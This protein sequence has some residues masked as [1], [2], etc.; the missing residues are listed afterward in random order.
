M[1]P[2][3]MTQKDVSGP[4]K[5]KAENLITLGVLYKFKKVNAEEYLRRVLE[6]VLKFNKN[7]HCVCTQRFHGVWNPQT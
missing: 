6:F 2:R 3:E 5:F 1:L 7:L 4:Q